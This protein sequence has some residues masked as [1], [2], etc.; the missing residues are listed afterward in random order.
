MLP[1]ATI[2]T[3]TQ[4]D[5]GTMRAFTKLG[6]VVLLAGGMTLVGTVAG[7]PAGAQTGHPIGGC[8]VGGGW[9]ISGYASDNGS[10][11]AVDKIYG[12]NDGWLCVKV[13]S[14]HVPY[15]MLVDN[16]VAAPA[17]G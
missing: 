8:A 5:G 11:I 2:R 7:T 13:P 14:A 1:S 6:R 16:T 3:S 9:Q 10:A 15:P 4:S 17:S 12:N